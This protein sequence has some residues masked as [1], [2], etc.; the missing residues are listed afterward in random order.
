MAE[1]PTSTQI[2]LARAAVALIVALIVLGIVW[3]GVSAE[4]HSRFWGHIIDRPGGPMT[5]R[6]VLQPTV[7]AIAALHDGIKDARTGRSPYFWALLTSPEERTSRLWEGI[8]STARILLLGIA[9][10]A[11]YQFTVLKTFYPG[12]MAMIAVLLAFI[13]YLLLRGPAARIAR[14]WLA[15]KSAGAAP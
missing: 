14:W 12:E 6:F 8:I 11:I 13:P 1:T 10:D 15:R 2:F 7:A 4:V 9:M 3:Y 5:F